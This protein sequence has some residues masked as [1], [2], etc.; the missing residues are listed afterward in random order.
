[1]SESGAFS[2]GEARNLDENLGGDGVTDQSPNLIAF[3]KKFLE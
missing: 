3:S 2:K 1:M